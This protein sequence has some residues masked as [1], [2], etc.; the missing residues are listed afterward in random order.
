LH[1]GGGLPGLPKTTQALE[2]KGFLGHLQIADKPYGETRK[3]KYAQ[4]R[5]A[6][7]SLAEAPSRQK[8][9]ERSQ[10]PLYGHVIDRMKQPLGSD[11]SRE[12]A[13]YKSTSQDDRGAHVLPLAPGHVEREW[14]NL[15][16]VVRP[17]F[18]K[19][20]EPRSR[21]KLVSRAKRKRPGVPN[22]SQSSPFAP[23]STI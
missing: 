5:L 4:R 12:N 10:S 23:F 20:C 21:P 2:N 9:Q 3:G 1:K 13:P 22:R 14:L 8:R 17:L 11:V 18:L 7:G 6:W 19:A 15:A 16:F